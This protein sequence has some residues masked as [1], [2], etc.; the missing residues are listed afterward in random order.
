VGKDFLKNPEPDPGTAKKTSGY[1]VIL[2]RYDK[3]KHGPELE[4]EHKN[5]W[6]KDKDVQ[7]PVAAEIK[8]NSLW[9]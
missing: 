2:E 5:H 1:S 6:Q 4:K 7:L 3:A 9:F 8:A